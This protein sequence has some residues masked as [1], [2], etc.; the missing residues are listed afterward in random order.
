MLD[1]TLETSPHLTEG[2]RLHHYFKFEISNLKSAR[3]V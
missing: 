1:L 2:I 3:E